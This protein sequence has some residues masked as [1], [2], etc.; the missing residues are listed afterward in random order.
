MPFSANSNDIPP[1]SCAQINQSS[2][3]PDKPTRECPGGGERHLL[4]VT[5]SKPWIRSKLNR[6]LV[7]LIEQGPR[8]GPKWTV[9]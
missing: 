6:H 2:L 4:D 8:S 3:P 1:N 9:T 5:T 7:L